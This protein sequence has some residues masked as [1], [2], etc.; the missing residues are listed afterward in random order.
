VILFHAQWTNPIALEGYALAELQKPRGGDAS[1]KLE[2]LARS[3]PGGTNYEYGIALGDPAESILQAAQTRGADLIV[4]ATHGRLGVSHLVLGSIAELISR[5]GVDGAPPPLI[6][7][8]PLPRYLP[9]F[10]SGYR[11]DG[12]T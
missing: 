6:A 9:S 1:L 10:E 2:E 4:I 8:L 12:S 3:G 11:F 5:T 7:S